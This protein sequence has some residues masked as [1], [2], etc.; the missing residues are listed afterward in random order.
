MNS[1]IIPEAQQI[2]IPVPEIP[3]ICFVCTGNTCRSPMAAAVY[4]HFAY[5]NKLDCRAVSA[6]LFPDG[7]P[8]SPSAVLAL[9]EAGIEPVPWADYHDHISGGISDELI[10]D[11]DQV[12]GMTG[13]HAMRLITMF[14][15]HIAKVGTLSREISDP[16]GGDLAQY[17]CCLKEIT[18][19][20]REDFGL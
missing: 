5:K 15:H 12:V 16:Y 7:S 1:V 6:G 14:P 4:N 10:G 18:A 11:C 9:E 3:V 19:A 2:M 13:S 20:V 17:K 8:I